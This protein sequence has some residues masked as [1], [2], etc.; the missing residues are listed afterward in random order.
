VGETKEAFSVLIDCQQELPVKEESLKEKK[1]TKKVD[2]F[3]ETKTEKRTD[4]PS[5]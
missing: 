5:E 4:L 1:E 2:V 3:L